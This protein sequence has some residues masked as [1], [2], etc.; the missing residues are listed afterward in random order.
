MKHFLIAAVI[1]LLSFANANSK[2]KVYG[3]IVGYDGKPTKLA[4][5]SKYGDDNFAP[6][7]TADA[8]GNYSLFV[9]N[10]GINTLSYFGT[11][12]LSRSVKFFIPPD[13]KE[14]NLDVQLPPLVIKD[15]SK[16]KVIGSFNKFN[17][18]ST[19]IPLTYKDGKYSA[20]VPNPSDTL[21]YQFL[22]DFSERTGERSFN[23]S[24]A[25]FFFKDGSSDF[26]S[27]IISKDKNVLIS[28]D[29]SAYANEAIKSTATSQDSIISKSIRLF[30]DCDNTYYNFQWDIK[31]WGSTVSWD[32]VNKI[33][34]NYTNELFSKYSDEKYSLVK[35]LYIL[36]IFDIASYG[37]SIDLVK[38]EQ[39]TKL[40]KELINTFDAKNNIW[41]DFYNLFYVIEAI[42]S[43][44]HNE[45]L[46]NIMKEHPSPE[47][48]EDILYKLLAGTKKDKYKQYQH[49]YYT[50]YCSE[51][52]NGKHIK[53]A[54]REFSPE[55]AIEIGKMIPNFKL[56]KLENLNDTL[57][58]KD[59][60][61]KYTLIDVWG[62]WCSP[63]RLEI[64]HL[65]SAYNQFKDKGFN[66]FSI[67]FDRSPEAIQK[68]REGKFKM[69]WTH[70]FATGLYENPIADI[71]Q[72]TGVPTVFLI[73]PQGKIIET[74]E[75]L[76][77][78]KL[79][80]TLQK[81]LK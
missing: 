51:Y 44:Y 81:Y 24:Q 33:K 74:R 17:F 28:F 78:D 71:F 2:I 75:N 7:A 45:F 63:C 14:I 5:V 58:P 79:I 80:P 52:P 20:K 35:A 66:I 25:D 53:H 40:A 70:A 9:D 6:L 8:D 13:V 43:P 57:S 65:D 11:F 32:S 15:P 68:F 60:L 56:A 54:I 61:G 64:P 48:R 1:L 72:I 31:D 39:L 10:P 49:E 27:A 73:D 30:I 37:S 26:I 59:L 21:Q 29:S 23:G 67:A 55:R 76:R 41:V 46:K 19:A 38:D 77:G 3:K 4:H 34:I 16:I 18:D 62:T 69:P 50:K 47:L 22:Y 42:E 36:E 12:H